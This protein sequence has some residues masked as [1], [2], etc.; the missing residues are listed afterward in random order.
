MMLSTLW[1][2]YVI[3]I[4]SESIFIK[5]LLFTLLTR[6][7]WHDILHFA[8]WQAIV[9]LNIIIHVFAVFSIILLGNE[10]LNSFLFLTP[11]DEFQEILHFKILNYMFAFLLLLKMTNACAW[12]PLSIYKCILQSNFCYLSF[13][14]Y[15][16]L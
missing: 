3:E 14:L 11:I 13:L 6:C 4:L 2:L 5:K 8:W 1:W 15:Y 7:W 10:L 12:K 9:N 16:I